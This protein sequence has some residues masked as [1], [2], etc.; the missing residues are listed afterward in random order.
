M[1]HG[2]GVFAKIATGDED[3]RSASFLGEN[4]NRLRFLQ[5]LGLCPR[6]CPRCYLGFVFSKW[7]GSLLFRQPA[8]LCKSCCWHRRWNPSLRWYFTPCFSHKVSVLYFT[9][10][11][12]CTAKQR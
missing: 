8:S 5:P 7:T 10:H 1:D 9:D 12:L 2:F 4:V 6:R 3:V 11:P